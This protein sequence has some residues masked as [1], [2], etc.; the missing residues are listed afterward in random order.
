MSG[1]VLLRRVISQITTHYLD[2]RGDRD[3]LALAAVGL[4]ETLLKTLS[5]LLGKG[6][7]LALFRRS[8]KLTEETFP[9]YSEARSAQE[10]GILNAV[11]ACLRRQKLDVAREA[12]ST[13]LL[14]FVELLATFIGERLTWQLLQE[15]WPDVLTVSSEEKSQ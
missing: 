8:L 12:T 13:L 1:G 4:C 11:G 2:T 5:P 15:A 3:E 10:D 14:T 6:G 9:C 7:S